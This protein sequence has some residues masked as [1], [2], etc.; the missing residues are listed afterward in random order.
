[1]LLQ[2]GDQLAGNFAIV[3]VGS[4]FRR[5]AATLQ[6]VAAFHHQRRPGFDL[7]MVFRIANTA[8]QFVSAAALHSARRKLTLS[9]APHKAH[10]RH[11]VNERFGLFRTPRVT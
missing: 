11:A 1:M 3:D 7:L 10:V 8:E 4:S 9:F 5:V 2:T 6:R